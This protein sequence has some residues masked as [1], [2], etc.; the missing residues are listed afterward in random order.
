MARDFAIS[1]YLATERQ[2]HGSPPID[3]CLQDFH[4]GLHKMESFTA[5]VTWPSAPLTDRL[6]RRALSLLEPAPSIVETLSDQLVSAPGN[7]LQWSTYDAIDHDLTH[8]SPP[9]SRI[10]SSSY[11]IRKALIRKHYLSR[12]IQNYLTK[13]GDSPLRRAVPQTWDIELSFADELDEMWSDDLYDLGRELDDENAA[14]WWILKP[15]MADRGMGIRLF[16]TKDELTRIFEGFEPDS[17]ED[18]DDQESTTPDTTVAASQL[19]HFVIQVGLCTI[20]YVSFLPQGFLG[21]SVKTATYR[22]VRGTARWETQNTAAGFARPQS[23]LLYDCA[24][25]NAAHAELVSPSRLLRRLWCLDGLQYFSDGLPNVL[26][27][28]QSPALNRML[29]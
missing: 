25:S 14:K 15:G 2:I 29:D 7:L 6:V 13:H 26:S 11:T 22:S 4:F 28:R 10:L 12:C 19:R 3:G 23:Q 27:S 5:L 24:A 21:I 9:G 20:F 1:S 16:H 18:E 8:I 17:D